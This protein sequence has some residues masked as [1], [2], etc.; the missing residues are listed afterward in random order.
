MGSESKIK[1]EHPPVTLIFEPGQPCAQP[2][3]HRVCVLRQATTFT[4]CRYIKTC[5]DLTSNGPWN[6]DWIYC[7]RTWT[8][9]AAKRE[10]MVAKQGRPRLH[11]ANRFWFLDL[12]LALPITTW[13]SAISCLILP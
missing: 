11:N 12:Q 7:C 9:S 10:C 13:I 1:I 3:T 4:V 2:R 8:L 6:E 5:P